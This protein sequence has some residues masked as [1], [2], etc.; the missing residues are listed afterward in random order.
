M[1][2]NCFYGD[3]ESYPDII[4]VPT[5]MDNIFELQNKFLKLVFDVTQSKAKFTEFEGMMGCTFDTDNFIYWINKYMLINIKER[6]YIVEYN[7]SD[8]DENAHRLYF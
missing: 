6:A 8:W 2:I 3:E 7:A 4:Y 1:I 5:D